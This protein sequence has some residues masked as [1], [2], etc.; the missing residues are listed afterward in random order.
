MYSAHD[1]SNVFCV[2]HLSDLH[3][4]ANSLDMPL[5]EK[6][7]EDINSNVSK[8]GNTPVIVVISGDIL[9]KN[10]YN[11]GIKQQAKQ[12]FERLKEILGDNFH[13]IFLVPGNHDKPTLRDYNMGIRQS[14][15]YENFFKVR[16]AIYNYFNKKI[17]DEDLFTYGVETTDLCGIK[18]VVIKFDTAYYSCDSKSDFGNLILGEKQVGYIIDKIR[19]IKEE[20]SSTPTITIAI[21]HHPL[22]WLTATEHNVLVEKLR[23]KQLNIDILMCGHLHEVVNATYLSYQHSILTL[24]AGICGGTSTL[25]EQAY[26]VYFLTPHSNTCS[27]RARKN[28]RN[29]RNQLGFCDDYRCYDGMDNICFPIQASNIATNIK[30][31]SP[32]DYPYDLIIDYPKLEIIKKLS[33]CFCTFTINQLRKLNE[34]TN[35]PNIL[36]WDNNQPNTMFLQFLKGFC[37]NF[38]DSIFPLFSN[39]AII[40]GNFRIYN[41]ERKKFVNVTHY[42]RYGKEI[43][44]EDR[45]SFSH[46]PR[47]FSFEQAPNVEK[48]YNRK[49]CGT[50]VHP[51]EFVR[52]LY[53][54]T[55]WD[56]F[57]TAIPFFT[58]NFYKVDQFAERPIVTFGLTLY[59]KNQKKDDAVILLL[60]N[61]LNID[62]VFTSILTEYIERHDYDL[63]QLA[64][65]Q[66][67]MDFS[68]V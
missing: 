54:D 48:V 65:S 43:E 49:K 6:M 44:K 7:L 53:N 34:N 16:S 56:Y 25:E 37:E 2:L 28:Y 11:K 1:Y 61:Y 68:N 3:F 46:S 8:Y 40:R 50:L 35:S 12:F 45:D 26:S 66:L 21:T 42:Y 59:E 55:K 58:D 20:A 19:R 9:F 15:Y 10:L 4:R 64:S 18:L 22:D 38:M 51:S 5:M 27:V 33:E 24:V 63:S 57:L 67:P 41:N 32:Y 62:N 31:K 29:A 36:P 47:D 14:K 30:I 17:E 13:D 39:N 60:M 23:R 52:T